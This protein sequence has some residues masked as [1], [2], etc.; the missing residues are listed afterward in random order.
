[1]IDERQPTLYRPGLAWTPGSLCGTGGRAAMAAATIADD[2]ITIRCAPTH[3]PVP[4]T[5]KARASQP[6]RR[7]EPMV[8]EQAASGKQ[9]AASS[10]RQAA[11]GKRRV[12]KQIRCEGRH[13]C[14]RGS[15]KPGGDAAAA[16]A[17]RPPV[18]ACFSPP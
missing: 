15:L 11:S 13:R 5:I 16:S 18:T 9:Q 4:A 6:S 7:F 10:K 2:Q 8:S 14:Q 12:R 17:T 1:M 3:C